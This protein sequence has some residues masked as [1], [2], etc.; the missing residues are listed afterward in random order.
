MP[1]KNVVVPTPAWGLDLYFHDKDAPRI[2]RFSIAAPAAARKVPPTPAAPSTDAGLTKLRD[3]LA[4]LGYKLPDGHLE[5]LLTYASLGR[6][7]GIRRPWS[8][9]LEALQRYAVPPKDKKID[10]ETVHLALVVAQLISLAELLAAIA[11]PAPPD[12]DADTDPE[13]KLVLRKSREPVAADEPETPLSKYIDGEALNLPL[14][15]D[16]TVFTTDQAGMQSLAGWAV[17]R[18]ARVLTWDSTQE[19]PYEQPTV[20]LRKLLKGLLLC[21]RAAAA[22]PGLHDRLK[23]RTQAVSRQL[24]RWL[25]A[26]QPPGGCITD[27]ALEAG[28]PTSPARKEA[29]G[30]QDTSP[31]TRAPAP[32][33][34]VKAEFAGR[35]GRWSTLTLTR[36]GAEGNVKL[37]TVQVPVDIQPAAVAGADSGWTEGYHY[38]Y[39]SPPLPTPEEMR[40]DHL[41]IYAHF[42][43]GMPGLSSGEF[44][45]PIEADDLDLASTG[46]VKRYQNGAL[47]FTPK[48]LSA[49]RDQTAGRMSI[50]VLENNAEKTRAMK[51]P[52]DE[53]TLKL[54]R[55]GRENAV[56]LT[57]FLAEQAYLNVEQRH[58]L[59]FG[60]KNLTSAKSFVAHEWHE[61]RFVDAL[62]SLSITALGAGA[63]LTTLF[64]G[65]APLLVALTGLGASMALDPFSA[66]ITD[67]SKLTKRRK[68]LFAD[69][70]LR[71]VAD[72]AVSAS[73]A[74]VIRKG[75]SS[76]ED[77]LLKKGMEEPPENKVIGKDNLPQDDVK[78][79]GKLIRRAYVHLDIVRENLEKLNGPQLQ[80]AKRY[81]LLGETCHHMQK[82]WRYLAPSVIFAS[83]AYD[84]YVRIVQQWNIVYPAVEAAC[85]SRIYELQAMEGLL[86]TA[87]VTDKVMKWF[88]L[89]S[90]DK[91]RITT[92]LQAMRA[93]IER[94]TPPV[95]GGEVPD[96]ASPAT[97]PP[98]GRF[99]SARPGYTV[100]AKVGSTL[101]EWLSNWDFKTDEPAPAREDK[102]EDVNALGS[103]IGAM[104]KRTAEHVMTW[105]YLMDNP[106]LSA[107]LMESRVFGGSESDN[108][109]K[110]AW[111][112]AQDPSYVTQIKHKWSNW[113]REKTKGEQGQVGVQKFFGFALSFAGPMIT[114][115]AE[116]AIKITITASSRLFFLA[117]KKV[118]KFAM[119]RGGVKKD[120]KE[121]GLL[122]TRTMA[123]SSLKPSTAQAEE[124]DNED[125]R[126]NEELFD[127]DLLQSGAS[128]VGTSLVRKIAFRMYMAATSLQ[129]L[130]G[131]EGDK[132]AAKL[133]G[134]MDGVVGYLRY[135]YEYH[136]HMDK[137]EFYLMG[138]L[139]YLSVLSDVA[140]VYEAKLVSAL[141]SLPPESAGNLGSGLESNQSQKRSSR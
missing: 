74:D 109:I 49:K 80:D 66:R 107:N 19:P 68:F 14:K 34:R 21:Q 134:N 67:P 42:S 7:F 116:Q 1:P 97:S 133:T 8:E 58:S 135:L 110:A 115:G 95:A 69:N 3:R 99:D 125:D 104:N 25:P 70:R 75:V 35:V 121:S 28:T 23:T 20:V 119:K 11:E 86:D 44:F 26:A 89:K 30:E 72:P 78:D 108:A 85:I 37:G 43:R 71:T 93:S 76:V 82:S 2:E 126:F 100:G 128:F 94:A 122:T 50:H 79:V 103:E 91:P 15:E 92:E 32:T 111:Q 54:W 138:C 106:T 88:G 62:K 60:V 101:T 31:K 46:G 51:Y 137:L 53:E 83:A 48:F 18:F 64:L 4:K 123:R 120:M 61:F 140:E 65:G 17:T 90:D 59:G 96:T 84:V 9:D 29:W 52:L 136:H 41:R 6:V 132:E 27:N 63:A 141:E 73:M 45:R 117:G 118:G 33:A 139:T 5:L 12:A 113:R 131:E 22:D 114:Q 81:K 127:S 129:A 24:K 57:G 56:L 98:D 10:G 38:F 36:A 39:L 55:I 13:L 102:I 87:T 47:L 77:W 40:L 130:D 105:G 112:K 16:F 124:L